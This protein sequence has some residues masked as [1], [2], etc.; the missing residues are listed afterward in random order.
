MIENTNYSGPRYTYGLQYRPFGGI[1]TVPAGYIMDTLD[2]TD[3][4]RPH[5]FG[6]IQY[7]FE[8]SEKEIYR[9]ELVFVRVE[10]QTTAPDTQDARTLITTVPF[11]IVHPILH[12]WV[13][14]YAENLDSAPSL[15][16]F[17]YYLQRD[18]SKPNSVLKQADNRGFASY[19]PG[20]LES[21][22]REGGMWTDSVS[23]P[24]PKRDAIRE[25]CINILD[26]INSLRRY[27]RNGR[28]GFTLSY[29]DAVLGM[30][31]PQ[32]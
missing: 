19:V 6:T 17:M 30:P 11:S 13:L 26:A 7:P 25:T 8:L 1:G 20:T 9:Y 32:Q 28:H 14:H 12:A 24:A 22:I 16:D 21:A 29:W 5:R 18:A 4:Q 10:N 15:D 2:K 31:D 27:R 23:T 3:D